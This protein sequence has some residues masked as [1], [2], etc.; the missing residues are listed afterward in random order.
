M[1]FYG[2]SQHTVDDK[3]RVSLPAKFRKALPE[4]VVVVPGFGGALYLFAESEFHKWVD[5]LF[6][7]DGYDPRKSDDLKLRAS[8]FENAEGVKV[9]AAGRIKVPAELLEKM[10]IVKDVTICGN[11]D[12]LELWSPERHAA[13]MGAGTSLDAF[14]KA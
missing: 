2:K 9:D 8:I 3:G 5:S 6:F 7:D 11:D 13:Y 4:E 1:R 12:H 10:G 14:L